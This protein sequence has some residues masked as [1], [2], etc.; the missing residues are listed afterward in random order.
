MRHQIGNGRAWLA[1]VC[2]ACIKAAE[3]PPATTPRINTSASSRSAPIC[4]AGTVKAGAS[5]NTKFDSVVA[6]T[7]ARIT[8]I[9]LA[10]VYSIITTSSAKTTPASG[11]L[12]DAAIPAA[13]PQPTS[14]RTTLFGS[15]RCCASKLPDDAPR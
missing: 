6:L 12:K 4:I 10:T 5:P 15:P 1:T 7:A 8:G 9:K 11:V 13:A 14:A 3:T 2:T